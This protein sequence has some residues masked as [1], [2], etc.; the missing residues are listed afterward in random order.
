M[1]QTH[2]LKQR[3]I[4]VK[5]IIENVHKANLKLLNANDDNIREANEQKA[6]FEDAYDDFFAKKMANSKIFVK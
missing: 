2:L 6:I 5:N 4:E 1:E 3:K